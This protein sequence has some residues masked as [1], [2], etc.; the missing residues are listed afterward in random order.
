MRIAVD[1]MGGDLGCGAVIQ[2]AKLALESIPAISELYLVGPEREIE[3]AM[4]KARL[5]D[6]RI[7]ILHATDVL[8][9]EDKPTDVLRKKKGCSMARAV[10]LVKQ[11]KAD[12][13]VS[14]GNTGGLLTASTVLL[15]R[16]QGVGRGAIAPVIPA[17]EN[18]FVL[19]DAG[20]DV[21]STALHLVQFGIMGHVYSRDILGYK[22]PRIG[23]LSN[24][25]EDSKGTAVTLEAFRLLRQLDLNFVGN[26]EGHD[27]FNNRVEVVVCDGF[28]GNI[29]L[30][31]CE[32]LFNSVYSW[33]KAEMTKNAKRQI[34]A[35]L[36]RSAFRPIVKRMH[37]DASGGALLLGLNGCVMKAH[38]SAS[39][40]AFM[41][42][43]RIA[44]E[45]VRHQI[46]DRIREEISKAAELLD[47]KNLPEAQ[48]K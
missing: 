17:P 39:E 3:A 24:G 7:R 47:I 38:G 29:V 13:V 41:N 28:V 11:G 26:V 37:P 10:E 46:N 5:R 23:I 40:R 25:T 21:D 12:A 44:A 43:I 6:P 34:G 36:V 19:I 42:A 18:E 35:L 14:S 16:L 8:T 2:G 33:L 20:A 22:K 31:T 32:S 27:L 48:A 45:S 1:V 30:K 9:M 15:R 4:S